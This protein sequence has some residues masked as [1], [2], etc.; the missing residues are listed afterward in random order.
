MCFGNHWSVVQNLLTASLFKEGSFLEEEIH[1]HNF[2]GM[3][4]AKLDPAEEW[5]MRTLGESLT[6]YLWVYFYL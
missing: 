6:G 3:D 4:E 2:F 1:P 5:Q